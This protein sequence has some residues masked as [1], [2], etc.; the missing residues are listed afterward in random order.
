MK[1][2]KQYTI[3]QLTSILTDLGQDQYRVRQLFK[4][5][6]QRHELEFSSMTDLAKDFRRYL[7]DHYVI[8]DLELIQSDQSADGAKKFTLRTSDDQ[9]IESVYIPEGKRRTVCVSTQIGCPLAC[10]FCATG[11]TGFKRDLSGYEI[12]DQIQIAQSKTLE[13]VTNIVFMGMG[14]PMLNLDSVFDALEIITSPIGM[15]IAQR[16]ITVSTIGIIDGIERLMRSKYKV[17]LAVSL[18]A[19]DE[20]LRHELMPATKGNSLRDL[21]NVTET[22][23]RI[24]GMVTFEYVLIKNMNDRIE[25]AKKL[26]KILHGMA[27]K[28]NIIP[29]NACPGI[30]FESPDVKTINDFY[31]EM[32]KSRFTVTLRRSKGAQIQAACGQLAGLASKKL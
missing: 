32:L 9:T 24:K 16:H 1:N 28:I 8:Q 27:C 19:A 12:A 5:L 10:T 18:N 23:A 7:A 15:A 13:R 22:Y 31:E 2:I 26:K 29:F 14:E 6:W 3:R 25:D 11:L 17:K 21:L 4:W 20:P 30:V